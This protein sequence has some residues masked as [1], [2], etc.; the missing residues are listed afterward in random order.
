MKRQKNLPVSEQTARFAL[1]K[2]NMFRLSMLSLLLIG[3][4]QFGNET[5]ANAAEPTEDYEVIQKSTVRV[6]ARYR[7]R[8]RVRQTAR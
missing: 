5:E 1:K 6:L 4:A 8:G 7:S 3:L 2:W